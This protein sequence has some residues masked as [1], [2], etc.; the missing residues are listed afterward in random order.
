MFCIRVDIK[1]LI[2]HMRN[3]GRPKWD[4]RLFEVKEGMLPPNLNI[5]HYPCYKYFSQH[6]SLKCLWGRARYWPSGYLVDFWEE[7]GADPF[8]DEVI[9]A[10][11]TREGTD[12]GTVGGGAHP[13]QLG[14]ACFDPTH[15]HIQ[16]LWSVRSQG[17]AGYGVALCSIHGY[18]CCRCRFVVEDSAVAL[19]HLWQEG[20]CGIRQA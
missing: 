6:L 2:S 8:T 7:A 11:Q 10:R 15:P 14:W 18:W 19:S 4:K 20:G 1:S 17:E 3:A 16:L 5:Q 13:F 9:Q 12:E